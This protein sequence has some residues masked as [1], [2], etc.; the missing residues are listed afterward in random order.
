MF[1]SMFK[2]DMEVLKL[3]NEINGLTLG[4]VGSQTTIEIS[5]S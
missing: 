3:E 1:L 2:L 5:K 4:G